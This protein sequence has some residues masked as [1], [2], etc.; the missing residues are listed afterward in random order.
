MHDIDYEEH[1]PPA[2][3]PADLAEAFT[4]LFSPLARHRFSAYSFGET[5]RDGLTSRPGLEMAMQAISGQVRS[6][7]TGNLGH[8]GRRADES[9]V[10][11]SDTVSALQRGMRVLASGIDFAQ[12]NRFE[13]LTEHVQRTNDGKAHGNFGYAPDSGEYAFCTQFVITSALR[14]AELSA[15]S[16]RPS[17]LVA[18]GWAALTT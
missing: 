15:H 17:W 3:Y 7:A 2:V 4:K 16:A 9:I 14:I 5:V 8:V 11:L 18:Q 12:Y 1:E 13:Q 6:S 10:T